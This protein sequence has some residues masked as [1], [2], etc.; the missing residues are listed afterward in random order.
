MYYRKRGLRDQVTASIKREAAR[1]WDSFR[2]GDDRS[3]KRSLREAE[4]SAQKKYG[5]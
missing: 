5:H 3:A 4:A 1:L 2:I